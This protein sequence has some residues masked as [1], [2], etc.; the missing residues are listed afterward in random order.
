MSER[1]ISVAEFK[2]R[3]A[4]ICLGGRESCFPRRSRDR[5]ILYR[6]VIQS[7]DSARKYSESDLNEAL[8]KWLA[9]IGAC[10]EID[11]VTLRRYLIDERY[12]SRDSNGSGYRVNPG[13]STQFAFES[14]VTAVDPIAVIQ[15]ARDKVAE[16]RL[17][18]LRKADQGAPAEEDIR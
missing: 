16:R 17:Q 12:L 18:S 11:H 3:L 2:E 15:A 4:V 13:G 8:Q 7:L 1:F 10:L 6:C 14:S 9:D 5:H